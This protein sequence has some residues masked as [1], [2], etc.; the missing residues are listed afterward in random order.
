MKP[1]LRDDVGV[2]AGL[3][4]RLAVE[5]HVWIGVPFRRRAA[6]RGADRGKAPRVI[7]RAEP[8][9]GV[10]VRAV[11]GNLVIALDQR[12]VAGRH[13]PVGRD[14][15]LDMVGVELHRVLRQL[16]PFGQRDV[17]FVELRLNLCLHAVEARDVGQLSDGELRRRE[18]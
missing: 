14:V 17:V 3:F 16:D 2:F 5:L 6:W 4:E 13:H 11:G 9:L 15:I 1:P 18:Q 7:E 8:R 10:E 12:Y